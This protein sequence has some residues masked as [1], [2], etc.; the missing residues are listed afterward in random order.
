MRNKHRKTSLLAIAC[1][2]LTL[3]A[4]PAVAEAVPGASG[5][6]SVTRSARLSTEARWLRRMRA[7]RYSPPDAAWSKQFA[8]AVRRHDAVREADWAAL[9]FEARRSADALWLREAAPANGRGAYVLRA[10]SDGWLLQAPH[11]D[12]DLGTGEIALRLF[13][14]TDIAALALNSVRRDIAP[15]ADQAHSPEG[16]FVAMAVALADEAADLRVVQLHGFAEATAERIGVPPD[17]IIVG[18]SSDANH[19][20]LAACLRA[21]GFPA[22]AADARTREL[23]GRRN[24]VGTALRKLGKG[25]FI[26]LE[27][28]P[29]QRE[30][31]LRDPT[32]RKELCRCL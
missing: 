29:G 21:R 32:A 6:A 4:T 26:H 28:G 3:D 30:R 18:G 9:G 11:A 25:R 22:Q 13:E 20:A 17:T 27:L 5:P 16:P 19:A 1:A 8:D 15:G 10:G 7:D 2:L 31:L 24:A 23:G 14:E 12:T